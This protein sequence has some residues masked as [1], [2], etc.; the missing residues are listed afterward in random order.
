MKSRRSGIS[1][2]EFAIAAPVLVLG[3]GGV[4]SIG[5]SLLRTVQA[6]QVCRAAAAMAAAGVD[7]RDPANQRLLARAAAG[8]GLTQADGESPDPNGRAA[9]LAARVTCDSSGEYAIQWQA[10]IGNQTRW[11]SSLQGQA[12]RIRQFIDLRPGE[13]VTFVET[14]VETG[15][16]VPGL[17]PVVRVRNLS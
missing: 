17:P 14:V 7:L 2:L 4:L 3:L 13:Q 16:L 5:A 15:S 10:V 1:L 9:I 12:A 6:G 8:L 11:Q